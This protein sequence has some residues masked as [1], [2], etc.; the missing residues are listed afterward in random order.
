MKKLT[1]LFSLL[2]VTSFA[3]I[4][5]KTTSNPSGVVSVG[6]HPIDPQATG[7]A[8]QIAAKYGAIEAIR[9]KPETRP[10]FQLASLGIATVVASGDYSDTNLVA[11]LNTQTG[12]T[13]VT[14]A[15]TDAL[16]LYQDFFG[17]LVTNKLEGYSP[18]TVPVLLG[19]S[20]G[21]NQAYLQ[22]A[23]Q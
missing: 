1:I 8:V 21:L 17:N 23:P 19:L 13:A 6:G 3:F 18:Y 16:G 9:A 11:T 14:S 20:S 5:C 4:G 2:V 12:N 10:Y 7:K 22:T 15:I